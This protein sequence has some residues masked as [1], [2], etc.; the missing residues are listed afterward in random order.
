MDK[1]QIHRKIGSG[2]FAKVYL[3]TN[4]QTKEEVSPLAPVV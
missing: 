2:N 1:Y 3:A 4:L